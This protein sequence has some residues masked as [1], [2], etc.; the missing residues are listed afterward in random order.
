V[1]DLAHLGAA[2]FLGVTLV[3]VLVLPGILGAYTLFAARARARLSQPR[4]V[5]WLQRA[6]GAVLAGA[7]VAVAVRS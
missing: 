4:T 2:G 7:A 1:V 5:R 3:I 6:T